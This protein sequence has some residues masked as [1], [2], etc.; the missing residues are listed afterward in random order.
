[1]VN[2]FDDNV[3]RVVGD[4]KGT[5]F[6]TDNW[7]GRV[8][9]W[10]KFHRLFNL[11]IHQECTVADMAE[12][13]WGVGG[14]AWVWCWLG[15][16]YVPAGAASEHFDQYSRLAGMLRTSHIFFKIIWLACVWI[17]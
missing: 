10:T 11:S 5:F 6:W 13:G 9:L 1:V 15:I 14:G 12:L 16:D 2:W 7:V 3:R 8:P 17:I 4:G